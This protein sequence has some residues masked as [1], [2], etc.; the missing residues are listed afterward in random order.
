MAEWHEQDKFW[1]T[2]PMFSPE[3]IEMA[4]RE[5]EQVVALLGIEPGARVLDLCCGIGRHSLELARRGYQVTG[6]D[7][8]AAYLQTAR[9]AAS[10]E[11]LTVEWIEADARQF[12]RPEAFDHAINLFTS[13]G[14]FEDPA[15]DQL[16]VE[17][18]FR[19]LRPGGSLMIDVMGKERLARIFTPRVWEQLPDGSLFLQERRIKDDWTWIENRWILVQDG[20]PQEFTLGHRLYDGAG[21][22][23]LLLE[24]GFD[25]VD[26]YG[27][28]EGAPYDNN[29]QRLIA[30]ACKAESTTAR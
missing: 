23:A 6:V 29:A 7:R 30:V 14:Y 21:L 12:V 11:S 22:R 18:V 1:E 15:E 9:R 19:S 17:H 27:T 20:Q 5:V 13:F 4:P 26:L 16:M 2:M 10:A 24:T 3:R 28:L 25:S 8:T